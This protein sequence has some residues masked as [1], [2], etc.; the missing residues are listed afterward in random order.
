M[1]GSMVVAGSVIQRI[2]TYLQTRPAHIKRAAKR[3]K[4]NMGE[5]VVLFHKLSSE[6]GNL[7]ANLEK[8]RAQLSVL[9]GTLLQT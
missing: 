6:V 3:D 7:T 2:E 4:D 1:V 8:A 9:R 5:E